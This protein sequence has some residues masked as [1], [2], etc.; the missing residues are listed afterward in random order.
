V[1]L[2]NEEDDYGYQLTF[3]R[4]QYFNALKK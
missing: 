3:L 4:E 1:S 2:L